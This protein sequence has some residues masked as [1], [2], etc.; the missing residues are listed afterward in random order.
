MRGKIV[1]QKVNG[2][3]R[4]LL[5][6]ADTRVGKALTRLRLLLRKSDSFDPSKHPHSPVNGQFIK[7]NWTDEEK[8]EQEEKYKRA[9]N[10]YQ[11]EHYHGEPE[12]FF[13]KKA[14]AL[15]NGGHLPKGTAV[16]NLMVIAEGISIDDRNRL[17]RDYKK[18]NG[19]ST[20]AGDWSKMKGYTDVII[21]GVVH[22]NKEIHW[23]QCK[24]IGKVEFKVKYPEKEGRYGKDS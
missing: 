15:K 19:K 22:R 6:K 8:I 18:A 4:V 7:V 13:T 11:R 1:L 5:F 16:T 14:F 20:N 23:Y 10:E 21:N 17:M 3:T 9:K 12:P 24:D 2:E